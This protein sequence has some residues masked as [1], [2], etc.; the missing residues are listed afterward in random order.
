M[1]TQAMLEGMTAAMVV[2]AVMG[3]GIV[4]YAGCRG[5]QPLS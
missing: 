2:M 1:A 5:C 4:T 3:V